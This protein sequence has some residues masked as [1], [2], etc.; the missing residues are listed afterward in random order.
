MIKH[1]M[2]SA[3]LTV[4]ATTFLGA[5]MVDVADSPTENITTTEDELTIGGSVTPQYDASHCKNGLWKG[6]SHSYWQGKKN[7]FCGSIYD[8]DKCEELTTEWCDARTC[9]DLSCTPFYSNDCKDYGG[10]L[11]LCPDYAQGIYD[12]CME[13][14][15]GPYAC[16]LQKKSAFHDCRHACGGNAP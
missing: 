16:L 5:C 2:I 6:H 4:V 7:W 9:A 1:T 15:G 13:D 10:D 3:A 11:E 8:K 12:A 14:I